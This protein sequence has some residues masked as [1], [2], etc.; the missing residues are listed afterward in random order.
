MHMNTMKNS[1]AIICL[2]ALSIGLATSCKP[3]PLLPE[4]DVSGRDF[5][6][7]ISK[8]REKMEEQRVQDDLNY[9]I[10]QFQRSVGRSPTNLAELV[11]R[12]IIKEVP[13]A[14]PGHRFV[15]DP[16]NSNLHI[17]KLQEAPAEGTLA[18]EAI[19][20]PSVKDQ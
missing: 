13:A 9:H 16:V 18:G 14:P 17:Q 20:A 12:R 5:S 7:M 1:I 15:F 2:I 10:R 4:D 19:Q 6:E 3:T 11:K 8:N